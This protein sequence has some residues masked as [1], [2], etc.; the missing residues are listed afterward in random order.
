MLVRPACQCVSVSSHFHYH[1]FGRWKIK[2]AGYTKSCY[3]K[4]GTE[5][6]L[7]IV[8]ITGKTSALTFHFGC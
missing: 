6:I 7:L 8:N 1:P 5:G 2:E 4:I 3:E